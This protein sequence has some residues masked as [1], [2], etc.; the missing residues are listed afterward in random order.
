MQPLGVLQG[1]SKP[2]KLQGCS[3]P[4]KPL[5]VLATLKNF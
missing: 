5:K 2:E 4:E 3:K 1:C